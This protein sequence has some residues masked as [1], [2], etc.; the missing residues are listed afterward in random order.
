MY[1]HRKESDG[2]PFYVGKGS[3]NR[4]YVSSGRNIYWHRVKE[5]H[6][7][8][9]DIVFDGLTE[10]EAFDCEINTL[11]EFNYHGYVLTNLTS[12]GEGSSGLCFTDQQRLNIAEGL[13]GRTP[14][15]KGVTQPAKELQGRYSDTTRAKMAKAKVGVFTGERNPFAD[16]TLYT[17]VRLADGHEVTTTRSRLCEEFN[18]PVGLIKKLFYKLPRK[19]AAGW[20]LKEI[21]D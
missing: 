8:I 6:G 16:L 19:S 5:K 10:A 9:V 4:A 15:N 3:G 17:F 21:N 18:V 20:R 7:L 14:W 13:K 11:L 1:V 2:I 12:G